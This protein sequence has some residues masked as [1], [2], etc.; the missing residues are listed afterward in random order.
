MFSVPI[1]FLALIYLGI[2]MV[3]IFALWVYYDFRDKAEYEAERNVTV[4][5][6]VKCGRVYS[7]KA[8]AEMGECPDCGFDNVRLKF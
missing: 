5:H 2:G 3:G 8:G 1:Q 6:C 4:F 7:K